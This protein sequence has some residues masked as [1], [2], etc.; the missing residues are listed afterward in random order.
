M[1]RDRPVKGLDAEGRVREPLEK[2]ADYFAACFLMPPQFVTKVFQS[3]FLTR[4]PFVFD[5]TTAYYLR[6]DDAE[7]LLRPEADSLE[8]EMALAS[9]R[10]FGGRHFEKSLAALFG[11]SAT[12]MAIRV[13]ELA[14]VKAWP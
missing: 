14:L 8:R 1:H 10:S 11:V 5:D 2:E 9:A 3:M 13:K 12:T 4:E 6:P 7:S